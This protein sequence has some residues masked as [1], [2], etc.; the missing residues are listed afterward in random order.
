MDGI[1]RFE[2]DDS[3]DGRPIKVRFCWTRDGPDAARWEQSFSADDGEAW[4][5]NWTMGFTRAP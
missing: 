1:G 2:G 3:H 5:V 4:E